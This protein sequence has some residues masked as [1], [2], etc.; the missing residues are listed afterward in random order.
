MPD[1]PD[2]GDVR[3]LLFVCT[4][5]TCRSPM[6]ESLARAAAGERG[7][8][9]LE[10]RSA[11]TM[12]SPGASASMGA[13]EAAREAGLDVTGHRSTEMTSE[14][15]D[16]ADLVLCMAPSHRMDVQDLAPGAP[17]ALLTDFLPEDHPLHGGPV[18]DPVGG[19]LDRYRETLEL[20]REAV[21]GV[22]DRIGGG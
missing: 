3:R 11:G 12:A 16:W 6:A 5:N 21:D 9:D 20:L 8:E 2:L 1:R 7:P 10:V 13:V 18:S 19:G 4:G 17:T 15:A 14:L 22:L